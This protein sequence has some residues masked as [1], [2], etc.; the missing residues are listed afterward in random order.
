MAK[1]VNALDF[2]SSIPLFESECR[3]QY[4]GVVQFGRTSDLGSEGR[5]FK[6]HHP[7]HKSAEWLPI[8]QLQ[9]F[10]EIQFCALYK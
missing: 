8:N 2:D 9:G 3:S 5:V 1:L 7:D 6:S 4:L 10:T